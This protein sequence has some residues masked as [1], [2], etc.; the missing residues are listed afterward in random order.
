V[1]HEGP[2]NRNIDW[3]DGRRPFGA[4]DLIRI[5]DQPAIGL[6]RRARR[7]Y[8]FQL[9]WHAYIGKRRYSHFAKLDLHPRWGGRLLDGKYTGDRRIRAYD[10]GAKRQQPGR[11]S[12]R[13]RPP[14]RLL[15]PP[16]RRI[17]QWVEAVCLFDCGNHVVELQL[18]A[19]G[20]QCR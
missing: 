1:C 9:P 4:G 19:T 11:Q 8:L 12:H 13:R 20:Y 17:Y 15:F 3:Q 18:D 7:R 2:E 14:A 16:R 5:R 10:S 6:Y